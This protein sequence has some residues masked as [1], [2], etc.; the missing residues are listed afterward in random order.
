M[1]RFVRPVLESTLLLIGVLVVGLIVILYAGLNKK[2]YRSINLVEWV[3]DGPGLVF[4]GGGIAYTEPV[5]TPAQF[6][7]DNGVTLEVALKVP[8]RFERGFRFIV[9]IGDGDEGAHVVIGQWMNEIVFMQGNDYSYERREP[10]VAYK[11]RD[12]R[13]QLFFSLVSG[14]FGTR[15]YVDGELAAVRSDFMLQ[16]PGASESARM[17]LGNSARGTRPWRGEIIGVALYARALEVRS[18]RAHVG[19]WQIEKSFVSFRYDNPH[20]LLPLISHESRRASDQAAF[21]MDL[22][23]PR[24]KIQVVSGHFLAN[25][26][27]WEYG[28]RYPIDVL[29]NFAGFIPFGFVLAGLLRKKCGHTTTFLLTSASG[30]ILSF[31]IETTQAWMPSRTSSFLD[32]ILNLTGTVVGAIL[33]RLVFVWLRSKKGASEVTGER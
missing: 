6:S 4:H 16:M 15:L 24:E 1:K 29:L 10:R 31:A 33:L 23:F 3:K 26:E 14:T 11:I 8:R 9:E 32:L 20:L 12:D 30:L 28:F 13:E 25:L 22:I 2:G 21:E 5:L 27:G 19:T 18:V 7:R 17:V